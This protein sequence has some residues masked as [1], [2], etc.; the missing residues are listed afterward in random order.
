MGC[1]NIRNRTENWK[2]ASHFA[3][4]R[5]PQL[6]E[7]LKVLGVD[8]D[9]SHDS[10]NLELFW[11]GIRDCV[12]H[13]K[14]VRSELESQFMRIYCKQFSKEREKIESFSESSTN[15]FKA[16]KSHNYDPWESNE[17]GKSGQEILF[18]NLMH[19]EIDIVIATPKFLLI[20]EA[21]HESNL[22]AS[23]KNVLVHQLIRQYVMATILVGLSP[24]G[25]TAT[26]QCKKVIPFLVVDNVEAAL[27]S[28]QVRYMQCTK[29][30][31]SE[32]VLCWETIRDKTKS[33]V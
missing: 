6:L 24:H 16:L 19:T 14:V 1:L 27:R 11:Y 18:D 25:K 15:G 7:L 9:C 31:K 3:S 12:K 29:R 5:G 23:S 20:G 17:S 22:S 28:N 10:V 21:K 33:G 32:R 26:G 2:T 13:C 30:L 8:E 4:L